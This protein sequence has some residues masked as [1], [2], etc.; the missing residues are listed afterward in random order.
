MSVKDTYQQKRTNAME[1]IKLVK[2]GDTIVVPTGVGE[3][4]P[5]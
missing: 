3:P 4:R 5:C 2:D 1:A